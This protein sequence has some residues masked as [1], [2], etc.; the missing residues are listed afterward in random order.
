MHKYTNDTY[1][2]VPTCNDRT[3]EVEL[4][5]VAL[6]AQ[7]NNPK[8]NRAKSTDIVFTDS[9][10]KSQFSSL[11]TLLDVSRLSSIKIL[12]VTISNHL[13]VSDHICDVISKCAQSLFAFKVLRCQGMNNEALEQIYKAVVIAKLLH[14]SPAWWEFATAADKQRAEAFVRRGV[15][16]GL[17]W[18]SHPTPTQLT[19]ASDNN[20]FSN[21]LSTNKQQSRS[22]TAPSRQKQPSLKSQ[23]PASHFDSIYKD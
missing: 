16:H 1:I 5:H 20:L 11:P 14:A 13:S 4:D 23:T 2:V 15:H 7:E 10:H 6:W 18:T 17:Y 3:R 22:Q 19:E 8:L 12:G 9:R 21:L